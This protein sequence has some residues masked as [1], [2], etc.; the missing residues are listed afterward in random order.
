MK[1]MFPKTVVPVEIDSGKIVNRQVYAYKNKFLAIMFNRKKYLIGEPKI[2]FNHKKQVIVF[3][4][5][6]EI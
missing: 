6:K 4:L 3:K 5:G 1:E 2:C